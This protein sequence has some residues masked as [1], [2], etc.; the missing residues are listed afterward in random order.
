MNFHARVLGGKLTLGSI[1]NKARFQDFLNKNDN[2]RLEIRPLTPES[3]KQRRFYHGA[4]VPLIAFYQEG[5]SHTNPHDL[6]GVHEWLKL[7]HNGEMLLIKG[8]VHR[9]G[10][11]TRGELATGFLERVMDWI[12]ENYSPPKESLDPEKFKYWQDVV[13]ANGG[14]ENFL[15]YLV[16]INVL[17]NII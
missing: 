17:K 11:S 10:K 6:E 13:Y 5:M 15:D 2:M 9:V 8:K 7:E 4:V 14:P 1:D 3:G 12:E 16:E